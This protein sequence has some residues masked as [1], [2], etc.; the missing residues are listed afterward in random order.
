MSTTDASNVVGAD[1]A[2]AEVTNTSRLDIS[3]E[4]VGTMKGAVKA[5]IVALGMAAQIS[6]NVP[7]LGAISTALTEFMKIQNEVDVCRDEC[8]ATMIDAEEMN[9]LIRGLREKCDE[10]GRRDVVLNQSLRAAF[11]TLEKIVLECILTLQKCKIESKRKRDRVRLYLKRSELA[12]SVKECSSKMGKALQQFN[13]TLQ[14][15]QVIILEDIR[16]A[17]HA[18][19]ETQSSSVQQTVPSL[20]SVW[21]LRSAPSIFY[22]RE[23]EVDHAFNLVVHQ[24]PARV[25]ILG[26]GGI[27]KTSIA[28]SV[29]HHP[30][31][32][33]LYG[34]HRCFISCEALTTCDGVV[35]A[36]AEALNIEIVGVSAES[37]Q[38]RLLSSL[39]SVTGIIC[40]DNLE[41][42]WDADTAA[43]ESLLIEMASLTS[44]A[45]LVTSRVTDTPLI[46]WSSP[47]L[48][49]ITPFSFE[50]ALQT[51]DTICT[52]HDE[53]AAKLVE[54][55]DCV[56]LAVTL[57]ARLAR[58]E[59]GK[60]IWQRWEVEH[61]EIIRS[62]G[63]GHR[64]NNIGASIEL[65][66]RALK[67]QEA[68]DVLGIICIFPGGIWQSQLSGLDNI[69]DIHSSVQYVVTLLKQSSLIYIETF[70]S[71]PEENLIHVLSPIR[72][73]IQQHRVSDELLLKFT[74][75][76]MQ[77]RPDDWHY[78]AILTFGWDRPGCR[79][80]CLQMLI[81]FTER[82]YNIEVLSQ[83]VESARELELE[84]QILS[85]LHR[86]LGRALNGITEYEKARSSCSRAI[87]IDE[88][89]GDRRDL[90]R[91]WTEW[92]ITFKREFGDREDECQHLD[93]VQNAIQKLWELGRDESGAWDQDYDAYWHPASAQHFINEGRRKLHMPVIYRS[94]L[95]SDKDS[96]VNL[97]YED[98]QIP[99]EHLA[100]ISPPPW[101]LPLILVILRA[102]RRSGSGEST[103]SSSEGSSMMIPSP[104]TV[105]H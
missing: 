101:D 83:V 52:E 42:P 99:Y 25:A 45:F 104:I 15:D 30:E 72:H 93:D 67:S 49:P 24:A 84:P 37:A 88:Q 48:A 63:G 90:F 62:H 97:S 51:W 27:G 20:S 86:Q 96:T 2:Q 6:Q 85:R 19:R 91:D 18:M 89:L 7:Y 40:L 61:T 100:E 26:S 31:V 5:A 21:P 1:G 54:A 81:S 98:V 105:Q 28:L 23:S 57:L 39:K 43:V 41:T 36:L 75:I 34:D 79:E 32:E 103:S 50:A 3:E 68:I 14:V 77:S 66:L 38:H 55:V 78:N 102:S 74:D 80:R 56:P 82:V 44:I 9:S 11:A 17:V 13:T 64:L 16:L 71:L 22:G 29:L 87:E 8:R 92:I 33:A 76:V 4:V 46:G 35:R 69:L 94:G 73:H 60:A 95:Y 58:T 47:P 12:K 59:S 53:Y 70:E 10:S 65:S